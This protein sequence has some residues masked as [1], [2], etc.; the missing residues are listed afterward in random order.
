V[1]TEFYM[2]SYE[3]KSIIIITFISL[4]SLFLK[5]ESRLMI[6]PYCLCVGIRLN[7]FVF[8]AVRVLS[9]ESRR[10][11]RLVKLSVNAGYRRPVDRLG[12]LNGARKLTQ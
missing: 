11:S 5:N 1:I 3:S 10:V 12:Y 9:K 7:F 2:C 6:L 4:L 8:Y